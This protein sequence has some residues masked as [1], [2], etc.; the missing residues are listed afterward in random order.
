[1]DAHRLTIRRECPGDYDA[2][3][4]LTREAF[5]NVY[6]PGCTEHYIVHVLRGDPA[7]IPELDL[8]LE[9][10]GRLIG[11]ILYMRAELRTDDGRTLP[12]MT[13]GP[14]SIHP[15]FQRRGCGKFLLERSLEMA[16]DLGAGAV[17]IEGNP[18]FYGKSGFVAAS[19]RGIRCHGAPPSPFFLLRELQP[20]FLDGAAGVY[21][22]PQGYFIDEA[23]A[24]AFDRAFPPKLR[25]KLP[26]Q[27]F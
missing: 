16:R 19:T 11:H 27:L 2:G 20:G 22:T 26:G 8:V 13:F 1:M 9:R 12:V 3:E 17:C 23:R 21:Y 6:R 15:D 25:Q 7:L 18:D 24:E 14:L 5:W 4:H 10:D